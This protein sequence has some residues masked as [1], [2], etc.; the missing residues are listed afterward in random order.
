MVAGLPWLAA[1]CAER[2]KGLFTLSE[3]KTYKRLAVLGLTAEQ[4]QILMAC[5]IKGFPE[6]PTT[7]VE[8]TRLQEIIKEQDLLRGRLD[9]KMRARIK[10]ILGV[11]GLI[12]C[13]Y[14]EGTL[15]KGMM[16]LRVR[17]VDSTTG[18]IVGSVITEAPSDFESHC[19]QAVKALRSDLYGRY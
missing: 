6:Q 8:R 13:N 5:Y 14:E 17:I 12:M 11:E 15:G 9:D 10:Q 7:F 2:T 16:K 18:A 3:M 19:Q 1:G 4:E